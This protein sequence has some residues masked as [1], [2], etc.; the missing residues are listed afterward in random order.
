MLDVVNNKQDY[1][2]RVGALNQAISKIKSQ[3]NNEQDKAQLNELLFLKQ[4]VK[5]KR[6]NPNIPFIK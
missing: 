2:A 4:L 5:H 1:D 3:K 6:F